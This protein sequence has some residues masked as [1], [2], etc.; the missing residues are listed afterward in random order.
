MGES[1]AELILELLYLSCL[2]CER[3][4]SFVLS[5]S[6]SAYYLN[7]TPIEILLMT[8]LNLFL[9]SLTEFYFM[10]RFTEASNPPVAADEYKS[11]SDVSFST[12]PLCG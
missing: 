1:R 2:Y 5:S 10:S 12:A 6:F 8:L 4:P 3:R 11:S 9:L 7:S